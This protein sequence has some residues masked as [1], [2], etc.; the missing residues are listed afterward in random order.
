MILSDANGLP[1]SAT[2]AS[3]SPHESKLVEQCLDERFVPEAPQRLIGDRAYDCDALDQRLA[4][5]HAVELVSPHRQGR[6]RPATQDRR[7]LRR[8]NRRDGR[9]N[10]SSPGWATAAGFSSATS[11]IWSTSM[12]SS[13]WPALSSLLT[14]FW[15][16][17]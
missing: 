6:K 12:V 17:L 2:V 8:Y 14:L 3:A 4:A 5:E 11:D 7:V 15:D 16:R 13:C 10:A 1:L 9:S